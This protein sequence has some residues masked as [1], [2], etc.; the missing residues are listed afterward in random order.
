VAQYLYRRTCPIV[1]LPDG[2]PGTIA[3]GDRLEVH[4]DRITP[5]RPR[6]HAG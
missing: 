3:T 4:G 1:V 5:L 2:A 6:G